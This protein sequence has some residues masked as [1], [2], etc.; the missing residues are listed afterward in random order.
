VSNP[1]SHFVALLDTLTHIDTVVTLGEVRYLSDPAA[2]LSLQRLWICAGEAAHR[3]CAAA[4]IDDGVEPWSEVRRLRD[5]L[6]H[7]LLDEI[8]DARLWAETT[9]WIDDHRAALRSSR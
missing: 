6:A 5:Y 8:D 1:S 9:A 2:R 7:H 3:H 4:G